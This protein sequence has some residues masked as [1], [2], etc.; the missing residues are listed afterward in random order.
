VLWLALA[1]IP[2]AAQILDPQRAA[3]QRPTARPAPPPDIENRLEQ[4]Q[5][6]AF[7]NGSWST[8]PRK[9]PEPFA[10]AP[11]SLT[12]APTTAFVAGQETLGAWDTATEDV[13]AEEPA[14]IVAQEAALLK[15][16]L[17]PQDGDPVL[18]GEPL[19]QPEGVIDLA[20]S[21]ELTNEQSVFPS[22]RN[23]VNIQAFSG[24]DAGFDPLLLEAAETSPIFSGRIGGIGIDPFLP[25]GTR[26]G[27]F[28]LFSTVEA[29][30][31]YNSNVF[32]SPEALG[33]YALEV[34]PA[35][36]LVSNWSTHAV[37]VRASGDLSF[38]DRYPSED[39]RAYLVEG[40][41]RLDIT[42]RTN[43]QGYLAHEEAQESRSA[44]NATSAGSRPDIVVNRARAAFNHRFN[45]LTV[46]LR[47]AVIDTRYGNDI[48]GGVTQSNAD[49]D[50]TLYE[51]SVRPQWE[52]KPTL[53]AFADVSVNQRDYSIPAFSD[54]ILRSSTG[55]R[56]RVGVSFGNFGT[57]LRGEVSLGYGRQTP[58]SRLP[59]IDGL[60]IDGNLTWVITPLTQLLLT[61]TSEVAETTTVDSGGVFERTYAAVL[62][63]N[64]STRLIGSAGIGMFTREFV[65]AGLYENQFSAATGLEYYLNRNAVLFGR[66]EHRAFDTNSF[67]GNYTAEEVQLG[68]RL[69]Q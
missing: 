36:R 5:Q 40:L 19:A 67:D 4:E 15:K 34:R 53:Y 48:I 52:F 8:T 26:I 31:D 11:E 58:D 46:Q 6:E 37:E 13:T 28:T 33:D 47:G 38:H 54:G 16:T 2:A 69:R 50:Y 43:L 55:E 66:Y 65:G 24:A 57:F 22:L 59:I 29:D 14:D 56:Y 39:D 42:R 64:F 35:A 10:L 12:T 30:G 3:P 63:H 1:P 45:R 17:P 21:A 68:V 20:Q 9:A 61:A 60:L 32:D 44:I 41:G 49:R 51:E 7:S 62:S 23:P 18:I 25:I 27:S